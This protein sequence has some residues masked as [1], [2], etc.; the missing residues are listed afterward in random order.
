MGLVKV[1]DVRPLW[2]HASKTGFPGYAEHHDGTDL[3]GPSGSESDS[4][5]HLWQGFCPGEAAEDP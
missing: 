2:I 1:T 5:L 3:E 4:T